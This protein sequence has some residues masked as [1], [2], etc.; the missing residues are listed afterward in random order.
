[1]KGLGGLQ[2]GRLA[3]VLL[4]VALSSGA[5]AGIGRPSYPSVPAAKA[6]VIGYVEGGRWQRDIERIVGRAQRYLEHRAA[7]LE[8]PA[9]VLDIDETSLSNWPYS[10]DYDFAWN[11]SSWDDWVERAEAAAIEPTLELYRWSVDHGVGVFFLTG[12]RETLRA[13]TEKNLRAV[14]FERWER[15]EMKP[16]DFA[17][18]ARAFKSDR[19]REI[20]EA[21]WTIVL[22][23]GD[24]PSDL[25]GGHAERGFLLPNPMYVVE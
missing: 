18:D 5:C 21:G 14:G 17:G 19:R 23:L 3:T 24:Q 7:R 6:E 1:M 16:V 2:A 25:E 12:R 22:T 15:L 20:E 8:R 13:A 10:R 9:I 11:R 4:T